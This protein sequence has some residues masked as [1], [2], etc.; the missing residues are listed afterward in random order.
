MMRR[1]VVYSSTLLGPRIWVMRWTRPDGSTGLMRY[2]TWR[3]AIT[4]AT[5]LAGVFALIEGSK[6]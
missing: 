4:A 1:F 3:E 6:Q 2:A 5:D